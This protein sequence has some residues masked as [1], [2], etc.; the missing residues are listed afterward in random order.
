MT[1]SQLSQWGP[2]KPLHTLPSESALWLQSLFFSHHY[3]LST[4]GFTHCHSFGVK[5]VWQG[6][7]GEPDKWVNWINYEMSHSPI[8]VLGDF[9]SA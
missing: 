3:T 7:R 2:S 4:F 9:S 8:L 6:L 1:S 5:V